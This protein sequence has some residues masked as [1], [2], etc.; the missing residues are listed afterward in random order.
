VIR[1]SVGQ[2]KASPLPLQKEKKKKKHSSPA[3]RSLLPSS[4]L[5]SCSPSSQ[6]AFYWMLRG[7]G[8]KAAGKGEKSKISGISVL[9]PKKEISSSPLPLFQPKNKFLVPPLLTPHLL[10]FF[11][12]SIKEKKTRESQKRTSQRK[13]KKADREAFLRVSFP[14]PDP[15]VFSEKSP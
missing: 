12:C 11:Y 13:T 8:G 6:K 7:E 14:S 2:K 9:L 15:P 10:T 5:F 4:S 3:S 1:C